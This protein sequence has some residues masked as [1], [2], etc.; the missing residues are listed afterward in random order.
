[1]EQLTDKEKHILRILCQNEIVTLEADDDILR[2]LCQN[3][4]VTLEADDDSQER[5]EAIVELQAII[6]K[7]K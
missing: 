2:I 6:E 7:L 4:I 5:T 3:E 1:M